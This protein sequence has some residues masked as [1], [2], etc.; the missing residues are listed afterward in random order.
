MDESDPM[1][2]SVVAESCWNWCD[3]SD[4]N[5]DI[6]YVFTHVHILTASFTLMKHLE[7][8]LP[9]LCLHCTGPL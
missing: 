7:C 4:L 9:S 5:C 6:V 2:S 8:G 3:V 1:I